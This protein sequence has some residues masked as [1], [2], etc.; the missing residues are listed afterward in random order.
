MSHPTVI[1]CLLAKTVEVGGSDLHFGTYSG[2]SIRVHGELMPVNWDS[3]PEIEAE[4]KKYYRS[5]QGAAL[6]LQHI[7]MLAKQQDSNQHGASIDIGLALLLDH[8]IAKLS[9]SVGFD[10]GIEGL[11]SLPDGNWRIA[12]YRTDLDGYG[13]ALRALPTVIPTLSDV[14]PQPLSEIK[15]AMQKLMGRPEGLILVT[16]S[17][18]SGKSTTL[19]AMINYINQNFR[20]KIITLEDPVEFRH[21]SNKSVIHHRQVGVDVLDYLTG[22]RGALRQ[23]PDVIMLG[24]LRDLETISLAMTAAETGHLV[25]GTLHARSFG[26]A[27]T[28]IIDVFPANQQP[29]IRSQLSSSLQ[30]VISQT[31]LPASEFANVKGRVL[32][33]EVVILKEGP[34]GVRITIN[35]G[36]YHQIEQG[37][38]SQNQDDGAA[39][40]SF[41]KT[42]KLLKQKSYI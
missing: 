31:L 27:I 1:Q 34:G 5:H 16:G 3:T 33:P 2:F 11:F 24:E 9:A 37:L 40:Y 20:K 41:E 17:T 30:G 35:E 12:F 18:G 39:Y 10:D 23:D 26:S 19:A 28:R 6:L 22:L 14:V 21:T 42:H 4:A 25:I 7:K 38:E 36:R 15:C 32:H 29:M 8:A 13:L